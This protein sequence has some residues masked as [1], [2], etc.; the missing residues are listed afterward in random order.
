MSSSL[1]AEPPPSAP[2]DRGL[3]D[4]PFAPTR[5]PPDADLPLYG[6]HRGYHKDHSIWYDYYDIDNRAPNVVASLVEDIGYEFEGRM[7]AYC[8][9]VYYDD[10]DPPLVKFSVMRPKK[11]QVQEE[12]SHHQQEQHDV[13]VEVEHADQ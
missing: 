2:F 12:Q 6:K 13:Q 5:H 7:R 10:E 9:P 1:D 4:V 8:V 3:R 11:E